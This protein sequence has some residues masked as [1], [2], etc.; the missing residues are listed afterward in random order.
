M[1]S[2]TIPMPAY[3]QV[4]HRRYR[5]TT[6][7]EARTRFAA[8]SSKINAWDIGGSADHCRGVIHV[9]TG[10][11]GFPGEWSADYIAGTLLHEVLHAIWKQ[12]CSADTTL[13]DGPT[14]ER[15][16]CLLTPILLDTLRRNPALIAYLCQ[17]TAE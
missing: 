16:V 3:V 13:G 5:V 7:E 4:G 12:G 9:G 1:T 6:E 11:P 15:A 10:D 8:E 2:A 17:D 14:E